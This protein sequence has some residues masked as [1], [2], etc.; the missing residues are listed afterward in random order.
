MPTTITTPRTQPPPSPRLFHTVDNVKMD[1]L[2]KWNAQQAFCLPFTVK[3][4]ALDELEEMFENLPC[5]K[6]IRVSYTGDDLIVRW[7]PGNSHEVASRG[8]VVFVN[9][10]FSDILRPQRA[11]QLFTCH[12]SA[13]HHIA[14]A[15]KEFKQPDECFVPDGAASPTVVLEVGAGEHLQYLQSDAAWWLTSTA[16]QVK[17]VILIAIAPPPP[18]SATNEPTIILEHWE[19]VE[20]DRRRVPTRLHSSNW[21]DAVPNQGEYQLPAEAFVPNGETRAQY[22]IPDML[23]PTMSD[24]QILRAAIIKGWRCDQ[25]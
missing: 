1:I 22:N 12:G 6:D 20:D 10:T 11:A 25:A 9:D 15:N 21:T 2:T 3:S 18:N 5:S 7:M 8:F 17:L 19:L 14:T 16:Y 13:T 4:D 24:M 23:S